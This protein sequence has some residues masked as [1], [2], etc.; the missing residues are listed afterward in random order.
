MVIAKAQPKLYQRKRKTCM[1]PGVK[2]VRGSAIARAQPK[3]H[4]HEKRIVLVTRVE[5]GPLRRFSQGL[6]NTK[7]KDVCN[8][9][10]RECHRED[11]A[12]A[13]SARQ[14]DVLVTGV[15][16]QSPRRFS[17]SFANTEE[18]KCMQRRPKGVSPRRLSHSFASAER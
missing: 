9:A 16:G 4:Q 14:G 15:R 18:K 8:E 2:E 10:Q 17:Q 6:A 12:R 13:L 3:P 1:R 7:E 11:S 5:L